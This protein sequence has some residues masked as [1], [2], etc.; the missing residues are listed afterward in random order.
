MVLHLQ[1][2]P[3]LFPLE[4]GFRPLRFNSIKDFVLARL[5]PL[6]EGLRCLICFRSP[7]NMI[8][9]RPAARMREGL[10]YVRK[11]LYLRTDMDWTDDQ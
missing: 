2:L 7:S 8:G 1:S 4:E 6:E 11:K 9:N 10:L 5:F 3:R